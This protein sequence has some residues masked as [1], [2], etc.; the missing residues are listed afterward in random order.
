MYA[1]STMSTGHTPYVVVAGSLPSTLGP[2]GA[3]CDRLR[4]AGLVV[5]HAEALGRADRR[6]EDGRGD[7]L[8]VSGSVDGAEG[9]VATAAE[10]NVPACVVGGDEEPATESS[11]T[12]F[13]PTGPD[14][15]ARLAGVLHELAAQD[16]TTAVDPDLTEGNGDPT[17]E[18]TPAAE[19]TPPSTARV[20]DEASVGITVADMTQPDEPLVYVNDKFVE[21]TGYS[22]EE[23]VGRN[24]RFLQGPETDSEPVEQMREA[25]DA[26]ESV[27]VE[28]QN[29]RR[30]GDLIWQEVSLAPI[31]DDDDTVTHYAGFQSDVTRR[32]RAERAAER[33]RAALS[34]ERE[35]LQGLLHR[36]DGVVEQVTDAVVGATDRQALGE[37]V[38][39][40][41]GSSYA[42]VWFGTYDPAREVVDPEWSD[43][44]TLEDDPSETLGAVSLRESAVSTDG[45]VAVGGPG[46]GPGRPEPALLAEAVETGTVAVD[47]DVGWDQSVGDIA[48][49]PVTYR[50]SVFGLLC[51]YTDGET[52]FGREEPAVLASIGRTVGIGLNAIDSQSSLTTDSGFE[53]EFTVGSSSLPLVSLAE[54]ADCSL[55]QAGVVP[56]DDG[57]SVLCTASGVT[58]AELGAAA[59]D[60]D[61]IRSWN[62]IA[63]REEKPLFAFLLRDLPVLDTVGEHGL[64]LADLR[65][66]S[67]GITIVARGSREAA[68]RALVDAVR[69]RYGQV[70]VRGFRERPARETT[71][72]EFVVDVNERLTDRQR[73]AL[74][75]AT[76]AGYFKWPR[77]TN[78]DE[79]AESFGVARSTFHQHLRAALRKVVGA[80]DDAVGPG[81]EKP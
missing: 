56:G 79:L 54:R 32:K 29:Y 72:T 13:T 53:V 12:T 66:D 3:V 76:A 15:V 58:A 19:G 21:Q 40:R 1:Y 65:V 39:S 60:V 73:R 74:T 57:R 7:A 27:T 51:V 28:L 64:R 6:L 34:E 14:P 50:D 78:G 30:S 77:E 67:T 69:E 16:P 62:C 38:C 61:D 25:I 70:D 5:S 36:L 10:E 48:A 33:H 55:R 80:F 11:V 8:V 35:S 9:L 43:V 2:T 22:R 37:A 23:A 59:D 4:A 26:G 68:A 42:A 63:D 47:D 18:T 81:S 52:P 49:V 71:L 45:G 24:C 44:S 75:T 31:R 17:V 20:L 46:D 41:L